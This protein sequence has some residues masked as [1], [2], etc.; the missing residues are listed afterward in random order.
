MDIKLGLLQPQ[1]QSLNMDE[2]CQIFESGKEQN[3]LNMVTALR[4]EF[5]M[6]HFVLEPTQTPNHY[7]FKVFSELPSYFM[8]FMPRDRYYEVEKL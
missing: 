1:P 4:R 6:S 3:R 2:G 8:F 5:E 7:Y